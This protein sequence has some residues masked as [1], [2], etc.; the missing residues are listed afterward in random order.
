M[1]EFKIIA[2]AVYA[3][4][5]DSASSSPSAFPSISSEKT[6]EIFTT[7]SKLHKPR[8]HNHSAT[9]STPS[10]GFPSKSLEIT[11]EIA[12][13]LRIY[14]KQGSI[15][16]LFLRLQT[17]RGSQIS[18]SHA[19]SPSIILSSIQLNHLLVL[20]IILLLW[21]LMILTITTKWI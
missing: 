13:H 17:K 10:S 14:T 19:K 7:L 18:M 21:S 15:F 4:P 1:N 5:D 12:L 8:E 11:R 16:S 20:I 6:R 9:I 2:G 3:I